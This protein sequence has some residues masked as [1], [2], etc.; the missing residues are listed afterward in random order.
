MKDRGVTPQEC[1]FLS[2]KKNNSATIYDLHFGSLGDIHLFL[3]SNPDRNREVFPASSSENAP[4][5]FAGEGLEQAIDYCLGGY[6]ERF[7]QFLE[8]G[9]QLEAVNKRYHTQRRTETSFVGQRPNVPAYIAGAPKTM[10][11]TSRA[12]EKKQINVYMNVTYT[13]G[14]TQDQ[15]R[16]RG[17]IALNVIRLLEQNNYIVNFRLFECCGVRD[18]VF[19]CE[20]ALKRPGESLDARK[21]YYPMCGR[22]FVR[23]I[24]ARLKESMPFRGNWGLSYGEVLSEKMIKKYLD[25]QESDLY[26]GSPSDMDIVGED[27]YRDAD[28]FLKKLNLGDRISVPQYG[29]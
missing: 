14:T 12:V 26:I 29:E 7:D 5:S 25:I 28:A 17:I 20:V 1:R 22:S 9:R 8:L 13:S 16:N 10:Y 18:E 27:I 3:R 6:E 19:L 15:I 23:R 4:I 21:C 24:L 11:R 2:I